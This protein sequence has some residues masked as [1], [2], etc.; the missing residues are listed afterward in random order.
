M[1]D[2]IKA[3]LSW[4]EN[5]TKDFCELRVDLL[6]GFPQPS[7]DSLQCDGQPVDAISTRGKYTQ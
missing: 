5:C 6:S 1:K 3:K 4:L 7:I 2:P